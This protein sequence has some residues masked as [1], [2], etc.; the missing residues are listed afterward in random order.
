MVKSYRTGVELESGFE[1]STAIS[2]LQAAGND[3]GREWPPATP[4][5]SAGSGK[6]LSEDAGRADHRRTESLN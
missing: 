2:T 3:G 5:K 4:A 1:N 6:T